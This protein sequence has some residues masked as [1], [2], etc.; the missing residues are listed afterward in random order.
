MAPHSGLKIGRAIADVVAIAPR[1]F[2][3]TFEITR[4]PR[5][6]QTAPRDIPSFAKP[7]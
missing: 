3:L 4:R 6:L 5:T 7:G 1:K 2:R